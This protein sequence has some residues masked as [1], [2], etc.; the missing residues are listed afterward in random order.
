[1][2][3][4]FQLYNMGTGAPIPQN[5]GAPPVQPLMQMGSGA[6]INP[7]APASFGFPTQG[8]APA[9]SGTAAPPANQSLQQYA[10]QPTP[11]IGPKPDPF[12]AQLAAL[13][14]QTSSQF[15]NYLQDAQADAV[16]RG[17]GRSGFL[18]E[19]LARIRGGEAM[20]K[21]ANAAGVARQKYDYDQREKA[22]SDMKKANNKKKK[23]GMGALLGSIAGGAAGFFLGG[24]AG[25]FGGAALGG[26]LGSAVAGGGM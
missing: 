11:M 18:A 8:G 19:E 9:A 24:P 15:G 5:P 4:A 16:S 14:E 21:A 22:L 1:M 17:L 13:D 10:N 7:S 3:T 2:P 25:A 6:A 26:G 12:A 23:G 20:G